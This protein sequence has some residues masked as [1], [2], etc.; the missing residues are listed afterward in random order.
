[1]SLSLYR[2]NKTHEV[3][4]LFIFFGSVNSTYC[5]VWDLAMDWSLLDP[6]AEK[7][8][9]RNMLAY[10]QTWL[11][12]IAMVVDPILRF[13][14]IFYAIYA[15]N[16]QHSAILSFL[17]GLSEIFRRGLWTLLRVEN[18]HCTNVGHFRASR[19]IPLPFECR[20]YSPAV[21]ESG[22]L[23][24][25]QQAAEAHTTA[26]TTSFKPPSL[27]PI[28][29]GSD[30]SK[31]S[32]SL[33]FR[34]ADSPLIRTLSVVG[35]AMHGAHAQDFERRKK[36]NVMIED[37]DSSDDE[38]DENLRRQSNVDEVNVGEERSNGQYPTD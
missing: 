11:Y 30:R 14:W 37:P 4:A 5:S 22:V 19:D 29:T 3:F 18:E 28:V 15:G 21:L 20:N 9:L 32:P 35:A 7:P 23:Q 16:T 34:R 6:T 8:F 27:A 13:N 33:R 1:M 12:Y 36:Q 25:E 2:I 31:P 10:R 17:I 38:A 26:M 24:S